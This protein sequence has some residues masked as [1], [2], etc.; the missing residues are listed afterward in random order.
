MN[1]APLLAGVSIPV[2]FGLSVAI[3]AGG[4]SLGDWIFPI[5]VSAIGIGLVLLGYRIQA[6][7]GFV[8]QGAAT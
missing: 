7:A 8:P 2:L 1:F 6:D 3:E 5:R 4:I